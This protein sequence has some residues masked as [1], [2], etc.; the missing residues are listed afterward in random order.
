MYDVAD[1]QDTH[2]IAWR[3]DEKQ[4]RS[5]PLFLRPHSDSSGRPQGA[6]GA[7]LE[8]WLEFPEECK[9]SGDCDETR[10][11]KM[12]LSVRKVNGTD[13]IR[14]VTD[15]RINTAKTEAPLRGHFPSQILVTGLRAQK[16]DSDGIA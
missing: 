7:A 1:L 2:V 11:K 15:T 14:G 3:V 16:L 6:T 4:T 5:S 9:P 12:H 8:Q 10:V 13:L